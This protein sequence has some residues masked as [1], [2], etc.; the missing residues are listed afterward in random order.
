MINEM[1]FCHV[2]VIAACVS[3]ELLMMFEM[4]C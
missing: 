4:M 3:L 2:N 1:N